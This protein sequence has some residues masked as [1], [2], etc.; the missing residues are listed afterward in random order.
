M[1][2]AIEAAKDGAPRPRRSLLRPDVDPTDDVP[3]RG[4]GGVCG[5]RACKVDLAV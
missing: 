2:A 4:A 5:R 3:E 1:E